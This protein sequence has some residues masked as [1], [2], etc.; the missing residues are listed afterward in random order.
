MLN[1]DLATNM[2]IQV[3]RDNCNT[4]MV[5]IAK[6]WWNGLTT[7]DEYLEQFVICSHRYQECIDRLLKDWVWAV[8]VAA[9]L[10]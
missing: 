3:E 7:V 2:E 4:M 5:V 10:D 1:L 6:D 8:R 9:Q